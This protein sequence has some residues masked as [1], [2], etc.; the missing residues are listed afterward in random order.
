MKV[1]KGERKMGT[2]GP[3]IPRPTPKQL[4]IQQDKVCEWEGKWAYHTSCWRTTGI[5]NSLGW[6][7]CP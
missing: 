4:T 1:K 2:K 3:Q 5:C 6:I 7:Y